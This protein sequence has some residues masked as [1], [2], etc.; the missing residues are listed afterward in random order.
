MDCFL[1]VLHFHKCNS[2]WENQEML[3]KFLWEH[4]KRRDHSKDLCIDEKILK[5]ILKMYGG[6]VWT[7][8]IWLRIGK[9]W[10][11]WTQW[12]TF[13]FH[14]KSWRCGI[15]PHISPCMICAMVSPKVSF[16][17]LWQGLV[18]EYYRLSLT[19]NVCLNVVKLE[20]QIYK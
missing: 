16:H 7:G 18:Y 9:L 1:F 19:Y 12:W 4:L 15:S 3:K 6:R 20:L 11:L 5:H 10:H 2:T 8:F 17:S 14:K 13:R